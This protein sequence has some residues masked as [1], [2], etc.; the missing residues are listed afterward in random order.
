MQKQILPD[1]DTDNGKDNEIH[2]ISANR[3]NGK[4]KSIIAGCS[5]VNQDRYALVWTSNAEIYA[6]NMPFSVTTSTSSTTAPRNAAVAV[7][8]STTPSAAPPSNLLSIPLPQSPRQRTLTHSPSSPHLSANKFP[9]QQQSAVPQLTLGNRPAVQP[10]LQQQEHHQAHGQAQVT[11]AP[12]HTEEATT[13]LQVDNKQA[14]VWRK[15]SLNKDDSH[16]I[17]AIHVESNTIM[18]G[19]SNGE[20]IMYDVSRI[21][22]QDM[23]SSGSSIELTAAGI[24]TLR[25]SFKSEQKHTLLYPEVVIVLNY[26]C[27]ENYTQQA[28]KRHCI[29]DTATA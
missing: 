24:S 18:I 9:F 26:T 21:L 20:L 13:V 11:Y 5:F 14:I 15:L 22:E 6:V 8:S 1:N 7:P 27:A 3:K 4:K 28:D 19:T 2:G 12:P 25:D 29:Y 10:Q 23:P 16:N 17:T